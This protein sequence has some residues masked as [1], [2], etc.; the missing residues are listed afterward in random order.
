MTREIREKLYESILRK[1]VSWFDREGNEAGKINSVLSADTAQ[2]NS[3]TSQSVGV[4]IQSLVAI[5]GGIVFSLVF[6]WRLGLVILGLSP[7]M[8]I[9]GTLEARMQTGY[10]ANIEEAYKESSALVSESVT[11]YRTIMSFAN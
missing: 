11:N 2:L 3:V 9:A 4:Y 1:P 7:F 10:T 6:S 5:I 8:I